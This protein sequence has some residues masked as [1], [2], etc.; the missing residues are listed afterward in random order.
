M[1]LADTSAWVDYLRGKNSQAA[2]L[3]ASAI[4]KNEVL[5][6][7][8]IAA[9][10]LSGF[11]PG[12]QLKEFEVVLAG[13]PMFPLCGDTLAPKAAANYRILRSKGVTARGIV[14]VIIATWCIEHTI[15]LLHADRDFEPMENILGLQ[16]WKG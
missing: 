6:G 7:D 9:E 16:R 12:R 3:L 13:F 1:I 14:D 15:P 5:I 4:E 8:L 10:L 11:K 2:T